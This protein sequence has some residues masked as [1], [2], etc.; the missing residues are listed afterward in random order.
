V[1]RTLL[2]GLLVATG[3]AVL[4][5]GCGT[6]EAGAAAVV[7]G[8]RISV[9]E[10]QSATVDVQTL[11]GPQVPVSQRQVLYLLAAAPYIQDIAT[12][13]RV[14]A[15]SDDALAVMAG[16]VANP[17]QAGIEVVR[18]NYSLTLLQQLS[19]DQYD[20]VMAQVAKQLQQAG[21]TVNPRYGSFDPQRG[22]IAVLQPNWLTGSE[23]TA[24]PSS[25]PSQ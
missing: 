18:A 17:S 21:F 16:K 15:S 10:V 7:G 24:S 4:L 5:A 1:T 3:V 25:S 2:R 13:Y 22:G 11:F 19:Q 9:S 6:T 8:R 14:G 23:A 20:Q 12:R